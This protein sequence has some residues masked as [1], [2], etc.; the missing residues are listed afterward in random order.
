MLPPVFAMSS[1]SGLLYAFENSDG[2]G[3]FI[4][5]ALLVFSCIAWT[6]M[7]E[8]GI[9]L[10]RAKRLSEDFMRQFNDNGAA[11]VTSPL[12]LRTAASNDGPIAQVYN[13]G[14]EKLLEFYDTGAPG[15]VI[16]TGKPVKL[17]EE[18]YNAIEALLESEVSHQTFDLENKISL[19]ALAV[20]L[21]PFL[22]LFGTVWGVMLAF[23]G[24]AAAGKADFNALAPGV[25]GALLTT[26]AGLLVAMPSMV[27]YN[28][29]LGLIKNTV[30]QLDNFEDSFIARIKLEQLALSREEKRHQAAA[31]N[32]AG[33]NGSL[34]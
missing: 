21:S 12:L 5:V 4:V 15:G 7:L 6:I 30:T 34:L 10:R 8:K 17:T 11:G 24:I 23:C 27:G 19:L 18:Q 13:A 16:N 33:G 20:S 29:I 3:K 2:L 32:P 1:I 14:V 25:S 9:V 31:E 22:G 28:L 26:V